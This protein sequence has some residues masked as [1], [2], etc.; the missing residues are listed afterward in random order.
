ME[1]PFIA[2]IA[3]W[4]CSSLAISTKPKPLER[5]LS[6]SIITFADVTLPC[7]LK[8]RCSESSVTL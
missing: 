1:A 3:A 7:A 2:R 8:A 5:P 6:R 4:A